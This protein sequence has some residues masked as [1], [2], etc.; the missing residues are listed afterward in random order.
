MGWLSEGALDLTVVLWDER[1]VHLVLDQ[2]LAFGCMGSHLQSLRVLEMGEDDPIGLMRALRSDGED[3]SG[4]TA[5]VLSGIDAPV[6]V[7]VVA[8]GGT[9]KWTGEGAQ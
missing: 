4:A 2:V 6:F 1:V 9:A 8:A 3:T 7:A 5:I